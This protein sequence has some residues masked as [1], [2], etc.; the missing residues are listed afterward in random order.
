MSSSREYNPEH[1]TL[2][3]YVQKSSVSLGEGNASSRHKDRYEVLRDALFYV[4]AVG[5]R[6]YAKYR[7]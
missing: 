7:K 5:R 3:E 4:S 6:Q 1:D 2:Q